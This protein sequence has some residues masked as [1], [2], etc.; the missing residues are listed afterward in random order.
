MT[1]RPTDNHARLPRPWYRLHLS[2]L[3]IL[4]VAAA[5]MVLINLSGF[6]RANPRQ[7]LAMQWHHGWPLAYLEREITDQVN[8]V[9]QKA[10]SLASDVVAFRWR[11]VAADALVAIA[12]L[13]AVAAAW[14][15]RRRC[16]GTAL[17]FSLREGLL[18]VLLIAGLLGW[19]QWD[20]GQT[21]RQ[22]AGLHRSAGYGFLMDEGLPDWLRR[23]LPGDGPK[24]FDRVSLVQGGGSQW[25]DEQARPLAELKHL[26]CVEIWSNNLRSEALVH[27][28][29]AAGLVCLDVQSS[30]VDDDGLAHIARLTQLEMLDLSSTQVTDDGLSHL[31]RMHKLEELRLG[32]TNISSAGL[33]HIKGLT[34]LKWLELANTQVSDSALAHL[35]GLTELEIVHLGGTQITDAGLPQL[36]HLRRLKL[37]KLNSTKVTPAGIQRLQQALPNCRIN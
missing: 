36:A 15:Y 28:R 35:S 5:L 4:V 24:P 33:E 37:L 10:W 32:G 8:G 3:G 7:V 34:S 17:Q 13:G 9:N 1:A 23:S 11:A 2:T 30:K 14:E 29:N 20:A 27:L 31:R 6:V 16:R 18:V 25:V 22:L 26:K 21:R 12:V 19:C